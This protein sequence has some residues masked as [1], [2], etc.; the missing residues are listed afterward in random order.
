MRHVDPAITALSHSA[1]LLFCLSSDHLICF[2]TVNGHSN[3]APCFAFKKEFLILNCIT[4]SFPIFIVFH[5][6]IQN[7]GCKFQ[8]FCTLIFSTFRT[9]N[10]TCLGIIFSDKTRQA[11]SVKYV[12]LLFISIC[13]C[14]MACVSV[15]LPPIFILLIVF[16][17][18]FISTGFEI[19]AFIPAAREY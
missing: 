17:N 4:D 16:S 14:S 7:E 18:V 5:F 11:A 13:H 6:S 12:F 2:F 19:W 8:L 15:P 9:K 1:V 10:K 3:S